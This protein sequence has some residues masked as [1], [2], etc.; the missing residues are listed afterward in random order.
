MW[1]EHVAL[2]MTG[3]DRPGVMSEMSAALAELG[4]HISAAVAWTHKGRA[5]CII[6]VEEWAVMDPAQV[7]ARL[8]N[9][10]EAH[11]REDERRSVRLGSPGHTE[12]RLHQ[13]MAGDRDYDECCSCCSGNSEW[14]GVNVYRGCRKEQKKGGIG[15][16]VKIQ[17]CKESGYSIVSVR[18][19]DRPKLLFDTVCALT[20]LQCVV[21]HAAISSQGSTAFQ[22]YYVTHRSGR[23]LEAESDKHKVIKCLVAA[24]ERRVSHVC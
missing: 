11:H 8:E 22:E 15:T 10:V 23:T 6:Y 12:R 7:R 18:S 20:E 4:C 3:V 5:A 1:A 9:V 19:R 16:H 13:L 24:T 21:Q 14:D 2:E 17:K